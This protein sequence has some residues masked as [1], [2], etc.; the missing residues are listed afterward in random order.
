MSLKKFFNPESVAI[1]GASTKQGKVGHGI[2]T[3]MIKG[4]YQGRIFPVNPNA[5]KIEGLKWRNL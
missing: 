4:G 2:L 5:D 1:V 3:S